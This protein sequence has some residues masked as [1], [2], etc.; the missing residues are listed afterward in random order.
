MRPKTHLRALTVSHA[1]ALGAVVLVSFLLAGCGGG[2]AGVTGAAATG[3]KQTAASFIRRV[4]TEFSLGQSGRLWDAL[5]PADQAVVTR[6]RY[7][8]CQSNSGFDLKK[9]VVLDTYADPID[10]AGTTTPATAISVRTTSDDGVTTATVHAV[11]V[12][13]TWR[14]VLSSADYAAYSQG[15]CP[16]SSSS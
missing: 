1:C 8:A 7:A 10:I 13:G 2:G 4:T 14:W 6:A 3:G 9:L 12:K 16:A 11:L 15:K 5:H